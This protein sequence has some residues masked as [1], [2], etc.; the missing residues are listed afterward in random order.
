MSGDNTYP[1]LSA[2]QEEER[3]P[4]IGEDRDSRSGEDRGGPRRTGPASAELPKSHSWSCPAAPA[5]SLSIL[6]CSE[7]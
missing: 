4:R 2:P 3:D 1:Y 5:S 6:S 7:E